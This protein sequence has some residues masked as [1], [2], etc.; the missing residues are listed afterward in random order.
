M[1]FEDWHTHNSMCGHAEGIIEDYI[2]YAIKMGIETLGISDHFP[3][4]FYSNFEKI[5]YQGYAMTMV[6]VEKYLETI[7]DLKMKY[8]DK[9]N[10]RTAFEIDY[11]QNQYIKLNKHIEKFKNKLDYLLGSIHILPSMK[12]LWTI[13]DPL[14]K[15]EYKISYNSIDEVYE[16]YYKTQIEMISNLEFNYN[17][18]SHLDLVKKFNY[19][20][21]NPKII[22]EKVI[23]VL[24]N[25]KNRNLTI[26][27]NTGG[28]RK[29]VK[30]QYPSFEIIDKIYE[31]DIPILLGSDAHKPDEIAHMFEEILKTLK[32]IGFSQLAH[33]EKGKR[34]FVD[35]N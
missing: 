6:Q 29:E 24:E 12:G 9:I 13:D 19:F 17:I 23:Q 14:L 5:P 10:I 26:E 18:V 11:I 1:K 35:I 32:K 21:E 2:Q 30:E 3:Y 33:Y 25:I 28:F 4:E 7:D 27:I 31:L 34:S 16:Q 8:R 15:E 22:M 20:P